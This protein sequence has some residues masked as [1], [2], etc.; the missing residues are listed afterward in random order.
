MKRE[1][2]VQIALMRGARV[3]MREVHECTMTAGEGTSESQFQCH[4]RGGHQP[5]ESG[6]QP[7][8]HPFPLDVLGWH[9]ITTPEQRTATAP[10]VSLTE[11]VSKTASALK[12]NTYQYWGGAYCIIRLDLVWLPNWF[13]ITSVIKKA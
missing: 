8:P 11:T 2:D 3:H 6:D 10:N 12:L 4:Q 13:Q 1:G 5:P 9:R 7:P